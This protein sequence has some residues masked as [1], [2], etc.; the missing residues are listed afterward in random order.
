MTLMKQDTQPGEENCIT[1]PIDPDDRPQ[2][3]MDKIIQHVEKLQ[4]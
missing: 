3:V 4:G 1:V 2:D